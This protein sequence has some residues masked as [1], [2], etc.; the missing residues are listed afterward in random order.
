MES[1]QWC[2]NLKVGEFC[3]KKYCFVALSEPQ[4]TNKLS[5]KM[6]ASLVK[7]NPGH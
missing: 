5:R 1:R 2:G 4:Q 7:D 6:L 3:K